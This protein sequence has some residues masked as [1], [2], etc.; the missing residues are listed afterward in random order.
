MEK[1]AVPQLFPEARP[2][3]SAGCRARRKANSAP[4]TPDGSI[5]N[6][7]RLLESLNFWLAIT[8]VAPL[9]STPTETTSMVVWIV[10]RRL[11]AS[12]HD[13][14]SDP[15]ERISAVTAPPTGLTAAVMKWLPMNCGGPFTPVGE[16]VKTLAGS[17]REGVKLLY[18]ATTKPL[19]CSKRSK[20]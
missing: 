8:N 14:T 17:S 5:Q 16:T 10:Q 7:R 12:S 2:P 1:E 13:T 11:A 6:A 4:A 9:R 3:P 18:R 19:A 20:M 15:G